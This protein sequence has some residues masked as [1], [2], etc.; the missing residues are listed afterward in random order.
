MARVR[1][2]GFVAIPGIS[3]TTTDLILQDG[4]GISGGVTKPDPLLRINM[5][6]TFSDVQVVNSP[7]RAVAIGGSSLT[8][9]GVI[10][11]NGRGYI[12]RNSCDKQS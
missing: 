3:W 4:E 11:N 2:I 5:G 12:R 8:V 1:C 7:G 6:G 10:V 9:S